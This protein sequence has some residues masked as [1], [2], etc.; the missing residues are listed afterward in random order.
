M[1]QEVSRWTL[2]A[3]AQVWNRD[4]SCDICFGQR[5]TRTGLNEYFDF[6]QSISFHQ[7]SFFTFI[8]KATL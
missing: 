6:P 4:I 7:S 8:F 1:A 3:A 5:L 2:T